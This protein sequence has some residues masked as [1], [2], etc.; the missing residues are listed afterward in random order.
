MPDDAPPLLI[1]AGEITGDIGNSQQGY[2]KGIA[3]TDEPGGFVGGIDVQAAGEV[4]G[5]AGDNTHHMPVEAG[6]AGDYVRGVLPGRLQEFPVIH[7]GA[8]DVLHIVSLLRTIRDDVVQG[9]VSAV[10]GIS[11][12]DVGRPFLIAL[13][14][15]A[16][17]LFN[18]G[19]GL[20]IVITGE[21][22]HPAPGAVGQG[23][24]QFFITYLL[25]G[26]FFDHAGTGDIHAAGLLYHE[27]EV[28][29][30]R[31]IDGA[32][33]GRTHNRRYLGNN[34]GGAGVTEEDLAVAV[35][36]VNPLLDARPATVNKTDHGRFDAH[37]HI[38]D[39]AYLP[40][41]HL[42]QCPALGGKVLREG[43]DGTAV[44]PAVAG[45]HTVGG[46]INLLH[47]EVNTAVLDKQ[48]H[49]LEGAGV[50]EKVKPLP[51]GEFAGGMLLPDALFTTP[52]LCPRLHLGQL[53]KFIFHGY[54]LL[55]CI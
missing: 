49:L 44:H 8:N 28:G 47:A 33:G 19:D 39:P 14:Q 10:W 31:G 20:L 15:V 4:I 35:K 41:V 24:A 3:K 50:K 9:R 6:K 55:W 53:F 23:T 1:A 52:R 36:G 32:A 2:I 42:P 45:D 22:S 51:G 5:L 7:Y 13:G 46:N 34:P 27:D 40:G 30:S 25:A 54:R 17:Q 26:G 38:H 18:L 29:H 21:L 12:R 43:A 16:Q 48:V 37:C 11:W